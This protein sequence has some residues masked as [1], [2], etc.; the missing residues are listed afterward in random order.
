MSGNSIFKNALCMSV[1]L[2]TLAAAL[3][4]VDISEGQKKTTKMLSEEARIEFENWT[5]YIAEN[6]SEEQ[7][8]ADAPAH[9][10]K[11]QAD[12][13]SS[14]AISMFSSPSYIRSISEKSSLLLRRIY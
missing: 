4:S 5:S 14:Q 8:E 9:P 1:L 11:N 10:E 13:C 2:C 7:A 12:S 3:T 6:T